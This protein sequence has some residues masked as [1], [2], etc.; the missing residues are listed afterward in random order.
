MMRAM[1]PWDRRKALAS[2]RQLFK[3]DSKGSQARRQSE[4]RAKTEWLDNGCKVLVRDI[5]KELDA[6]DTVF[7]PVRDEITG[8]RGG[9]RAATAGCRCMGMGALADEDDKT[10]LAVF[11]KTE[12]SVDAML[13]LWEKRKKALQQLEPTHEWYAHWCRY[14]DT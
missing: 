12:Y 8:D 9:I 1:I 4:K 13:D 2:L 11:K 10:M 5:M 6:P 3:E 7:R 14:L